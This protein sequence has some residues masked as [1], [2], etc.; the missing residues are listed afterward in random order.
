[1][2][3]ELSI[4]S[5]RLITEDK[6]PAPPTEL[7]VTSRLTETGRPC[8]SLLDQGLTVGMPSFVQARHS[9]HWQVL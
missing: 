8:D 9:G 5:A 1:M 4:E 3:L 7:S 2:H 6:E